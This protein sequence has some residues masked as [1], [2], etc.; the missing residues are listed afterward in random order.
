MSRKSTPGRRGINLLTKTA[1]RKEK[2]ALR[3]P[4]VERPWEHWKCAVVAKLDSLHSE[5]AT[6][7]SIVFIVIKNCLSK[8]MTTGLG[9]KTSLSVVLF[10]TRCIAF[11]RR[12]MVNYW[13]QQGR[14]SANTAKKAFLKL[15]AFTSTS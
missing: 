8:E 14:S 2:M 6:N 7:V 5:V 3:S 4:T 12:K 1:S 15:I 10:R 13:P 11:V 9:V